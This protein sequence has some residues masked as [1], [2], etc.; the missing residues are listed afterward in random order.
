MNTE[1]FTCIAGFA[2]SNLRQQLLYFYTEQTDE[3]P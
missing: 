1:T 3:K 2:R